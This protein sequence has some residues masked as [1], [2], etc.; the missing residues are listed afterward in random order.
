MAGAECEQLR[1]ELAEA[2]HTIKALWKIIYTRRFSRN[3]RIIRRLLPRVLH[4]HWDEWNFRRFEKIIDRSGKF[5]RYWYLSTYSDVAESGMDPLKHYVRRGALEGRWPRADFDPVGYVCQHPYLGLLNVEPFVHFT[6]HAEH[7]NSRCDVGSNVGSMRLEQSSPSSSEI[8]IPIAVPDQLRGAVDEINSQLIQAKLKVTVVIPCFNYGK[9]I[10]EA[11]ISVLEQ[12]YPYFD[13]VI[14]DDGSTDNSGEICDRLATDPRVTVI[15]QTNQG[16][17]AA[18]NAGARASRAEFLLFL[19]ADDLLDPSAISVMLWSLWKNPSAAYVYSSQ[20]FFGDQELVWEP[21]EFNGFDLLWSNHPSVCSLIRREAFDCVGGY[22]SGMVVGYE[23]WNHWVMLLNAGLYGMRL[24]APLFKHRRHGITMTH[25]AHARQRLLHHKI[26]SHSSEI[27]KN[28]NI[29]QLKA[30]WRPAVS[31]IIPF[32]NSHRYFPETIASVYAQTIRDYEIIIVNDGSDDSASTGMLQELKAEGCATGAPLRIIDCDHR[33]APATRNEGARAAK[34]EFIFFLDADDILSPT[35]L[36]KLILAA[37]TNPAVSYFYS[38]VRHFGSINGIASDPF[39]PE[40][41]KRENFLTVSCLIRTSAYLDAGGMDEA[42]LD[43]YEDYD[44]WLR[45][46]SMGHIGMHVPEIL[47]HYRRHSH[48]YRTALERS[49]SPDAMYKRLRAR[50]PILFG[51][52]EPDRTSWRL[53]ASSTEGADQKRFE[54]LFRKAQP[55]QLPRE[56]YRRP[57]LPN[58]FDPVRW[59]KRVPRILYLVPFFVYGGAEQVDLEIL[60]GFREAGFE[61]TLVA[62]EDA[63]HTWLSRFENIVSD[64]FILQNFAGDRVARDKIIDYLMVSRSIDVV[65]IRN[66][67]Y[68]YSL[69]ERWKRISNAVAFVDLLHLHAFGE[70]WV[71]HSA[72]YHELLVHRFVIT[73]DLKSYAETT[74]RLDGQKIQVI[75]NGIDPLE[76]VSVDEFR[77][78]SIEVR[79]TL[80]LRLDAPIVAYCGRV[81]EQKDPLRWVRVVSEVLKRRPDAQPIV[82][83]DGELLH[84]MKGEAARLGISEKIHFLGYRADIKQILPA[85]DVLLMTSRYEG[86]PQVILEALACGVPVVSTDVGGVRECLDEKIGKLLDVNAGDVEMADAVLQVIDMGYDNSSLRE[87]CRR[88]VEERFH[89]SQQ[90]ASYCCSVETIANSLSYD[91]RRE[92]YLDRVMEGPLLG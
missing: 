12:T 40:R 42:L 38:S 74:Y 18:R 92:D 39:D 37:A 70:D 9:F 81:A 47:F 43:N 10:E 59:T 2:R 58:M 8:S 61:I 33:G 25:E 88:T 54:T 17:A 86:L 69:C 75:H 65:F 29:S 83:G 90:R 31:I 36:E 1:G 4:P 27:Y 23:D 48:G 82:V 13:V 5:D 22:S 64:I 16:L 6:T 7:V 56:S 85:L 30:Q 52:P 79:S 77:S 80:G 63:D 53:I 66:T 26:R 41:L 15:H 3:R 34:S 55:S 35:T 73:H 68:G 21:Q 67:S 71:R 11:V 87:L 78:K 51:G 44:F 72:V 20:R 46:L 19:D 76:F 57:C 60:K 50:H 24:Q 28:E 62:C 32:Y 89:V 84:S 45:M 91:Q 49:S 14:V